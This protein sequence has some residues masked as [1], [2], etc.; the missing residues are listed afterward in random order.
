[1]AR[2]TRFSSNPWAAIEALS[3]ANAVLPADVLRTLAGDSSSWLSG[4]DWMTGS[5]MAVILLKR[6]SR[7][8]A[9]SDG[10]VGESRRHSPWRPALNPLGPGLY[11]LKRWGGWLAG[12][13][14]RAVAV[15]RF[16][17][18]ALYRCG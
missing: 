1:M 8:G 2:A 10:D 13:L 9:A 5:D 11:P 17:L 6:E 14:V 3:S 15:E 16:N 12:G 7:P 4:M 18:G